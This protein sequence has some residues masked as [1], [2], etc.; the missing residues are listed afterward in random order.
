LPEAPLF[1]VQW[2][3]CFRWRAGDAHDVDIV[4]WVNLQAHYDVERAEIKLAAR[5]K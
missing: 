5:V 4:D 2:R 1:R 3:N